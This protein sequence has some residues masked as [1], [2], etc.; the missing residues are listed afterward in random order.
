MTYALALFEIA[1]FM[2]FGAAVTLAATFVTSFRYFFGFAWR[3][4]LWGTIGLLLG[5]LTLFGALSPFVVS[6]GIAGVPAG[7]VRFQDI[8]LFQAL[9]FGPILVTSLGIFLGCLYGWRRARRLANLGV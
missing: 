2:L 9:L 5:N 4:W 8:L 1:L 7:H 3:M 6:V